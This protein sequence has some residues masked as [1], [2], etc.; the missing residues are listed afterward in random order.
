MALTQEQFIELEG[1]IQ[2]YWTACEKANKD[3]LPI[4]FNMGKSG[5]ARELHHSFGTA[6]RMQDFNGSVHYDTISDGLE[7]EYRHNA[8][9]IGIPI[10]WR[11]YEDKEYNKI[12][13]L[14]NEINYGIYKT[15]QYDGSSVFNNGFTD[16]AAYHGVDS[17][18]LFSASHYIISS[19]EDAQ[20]NYGTDDM[21]I[22]AIT[23]IQKAGMSYKDNRGD[24]MLVE[25]DTIWCGVHWMDKAKKIV[26]S[27]KEPFTSDNQTNIY[28][29]LKLIINPWITGKK[30]G[31]LSSRL[32]KGGNGLN[33]YMRQDPRKIERDSEF[34]S[35][36]LKWRGVGRWSY[37]WNN[38]WVAYGMSPA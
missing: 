10:D 27:E 38:W 8:K 2:E 31:M 15:L 32:A 4:M 37:G 28:N 18:P 7:K 17:K 3:Y 11:L 14:V 33:F 9:T 34:D 30:W 19:G 21:D 12:K 1:N 35:L 13:T 6:G 22:D 24:L 20:S 16:L 29:T 26:G 36:V 23:E 5:G 25:Y